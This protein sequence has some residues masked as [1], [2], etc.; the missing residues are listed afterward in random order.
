MNKFELPK[1]KYE[2]DA[3]SPVISNDTMSL[4]YG[5]HHQAYVD[6]LNKALSECADANGLSLLELASDS[7][8]ITCANKQ[9]ILNNAGGHYNHSLFWKVMKPFSSDETN[10]PSDELAEMI[11]AKYGSFE[12][13]VDKFSEYA[14]GRFGSGWVFLQP[15]GEIVSTA[16]QD[17]PMMQ[18]LSEPILG[19]DVWEH[20]YYLDYQNKRGDYINNWWQIVDWKAVQDRFGKSNHSYPLKTN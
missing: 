7:E 20:A 19:L 9:A 1:L 8:Q 14:L 17:T 2:L 3:L 4:H 15:D 11:D 18:G 16:N 12:G 10:K 5:K 6:N 13:F